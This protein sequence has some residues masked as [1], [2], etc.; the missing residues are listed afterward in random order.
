MCTY[1]KVKKMKVFRVQLF[2]TPGTVTHQAP[3]SIQFSRQEC[4]S[5]SPFSSPGHLRDPE[6]EFRSPAVQADSLPFEPRGCTYVSTGQTSFWF[7]FFN[8]KVFLVFF[9]LEDNCFAMFCWFF[10]A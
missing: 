10:G 3:L 4:W 1:V 9:K 2:I 8:K 7:C 6:I 5:G